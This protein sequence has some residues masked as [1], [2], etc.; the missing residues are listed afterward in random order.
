[1]TLNVRRHQESAL[2][3][4]AE[5]IKFDTEHWGKG[6]ATEAERGALRI[7][8]E[9]LGFPEIVSST[10]VGNVR[11]RAVMVRTKRSK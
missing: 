6:F 7:D 3:Q 2:K 1:M 9:R 4:M 5:P 8:F 10:S 11:S